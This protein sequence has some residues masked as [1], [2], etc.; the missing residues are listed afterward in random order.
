[1]EHHA[2][3]ILEDVNLTHSEW[4]WNGQR[5]GTMHFTILLGLES[6]VFYSFFFFFFSFERVGYRVCSYSLLH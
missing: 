6:E 2:A 5:Q 3:A 1:M 4:H